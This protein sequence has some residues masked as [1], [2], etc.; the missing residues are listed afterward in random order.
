[1]IKI[2][3]LFVLLLP[4]ANLESHE[5]NPAHLIINQNNNN[6]GA[7]DATWMYPVKNAGKKAEVIFP[8]VCISEASDPY[9]QGKY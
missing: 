9:V 8:D 2:F 3:F 1:M 7:Y 5:F 6:E 4:I